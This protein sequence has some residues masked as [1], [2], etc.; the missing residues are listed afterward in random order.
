MANLATLLVLIADHVLT[1]VPVS[2]NS[3][4]EAKEVLDTLLDMDINHH[5]HE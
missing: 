4:N 1:A 2:E 5:P 3:K